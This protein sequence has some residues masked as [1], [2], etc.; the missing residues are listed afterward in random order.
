MANEEKKEKDEGIV[1]T[2]LPIA[3]RHAALLDIQKQLQGHELE[4]TVEVAGHKFH[5]T[6]INSDEEMWADGFM[7]TDSTPQAVSSYRKSRLA[8][9]I[10][11]IDN[12]PITEMFEFPED[13]DEDTKRQFTMSRYG[14]RTWQMNQLYVWL[15][16]LG[17]PI[18]DQ[19][20]TEYQKI[21]RQRKESL[22]NLKNSSAGI[23]GGESKDTSS[24]EKE[25]SLVTQM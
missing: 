5:M 16:E 18:I 8:A 15:G 22:D 21:S 19:L 7:Q 13:M 1:L 11:S 3:K 20:A 10:K 24:P 23:P 4:T 17:M 2:S 9:S 12:I 25:S 14:E 6:T